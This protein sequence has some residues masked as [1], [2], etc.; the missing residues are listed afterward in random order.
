MIWSNIAVGNKGVFFFKDVPIAVFLY[1]SFQIN[2]GKVRNFFFVK[3]NP[4]KSRL[5]KQLLPLK[6]FRLQH[7]LVQFPLQNEQIWYLLLFVFLML[8]SYP[9]WYNNVLTIQKTLRMLNVSIWLQSIIIFLA[10]RLLQVLFFFLTS[11][12]FHKATN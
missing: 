1:T 3:F 4:K 5:T 2:N 10:N 8:F 6:Q 12:Q 11:Y 9:Q 7:M